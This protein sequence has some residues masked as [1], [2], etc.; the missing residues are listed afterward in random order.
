[1]LDHGHTG[2]CLLATASCVDCRWLEDTT[3]GAGIC[4]GRSCRFQVRMGQLVFR[5]Y[6]LIFKLQSAA[7]GCARRREAGD[8]VGCQMVM[9]ANEAGPDPGRR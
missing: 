5:S 9:A 2:W 6:R 1:M 4:T 8:G 7:G 3:G